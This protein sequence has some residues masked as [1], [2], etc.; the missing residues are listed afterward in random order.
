VCTIPEHFL[1]QDGAEGARRRVR[2]LPAEEGFDEVNDGLDDDRGA[3]GGE[4]E[5]SVHGVCENLSA[6]EVRSPS[7]GTGS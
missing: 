2:A 5:D 3:N 6:H 4:E 1:S 7:F